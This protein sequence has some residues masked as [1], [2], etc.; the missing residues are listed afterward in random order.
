[1]LKYKNVVAGARGF[2][3]IEVLIAVFVLAVGILGA[4]AIQTIG[5]QANQGAYLRSQAM[6]LASDMLDRIR[7]N[8]D[9]RATY[10]NLDTDTDTTTS[11]GCSSSASGC[12]AA[13]LAREDIVAWRTAVET[14]IDSGGYLPNGRGRVTAGAGNNVVI[15]ITWNETDWVGNVRGSSTPSYSIAAAINP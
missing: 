12:T 11:P 10:L 13:N 2:A 15:T 7:M 3:L 4:G 6:F 8:R 9:A 14:S 1:M 5:L